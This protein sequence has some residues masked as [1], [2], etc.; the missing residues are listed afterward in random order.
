MTGIPV[1]CMGVF[2]PLG[3]RLAARVGPRM[4]FT[5]AVASIGM[6]GVLR[7]LAPAYPLILLATFGIGVAIGV[8]GALPAMV[9]AQRLPRTPALGTG[10]YVAGIAAG[11]TV[12][13]AVAVP[14][15]IDGDWRLSL[16]L[17]S[18]TTTVFL[19]AWLALVPNDHHE[20]RSSAVRPPLPWRSRT[21]W[22]LILVFGLE[23]GL[24]YGCV[25][26]LATI[27]V[28]RGWTT[29]AAG[30]LAAVFNAAGLA[31][32]LTVPLVADR[33]PHRGRV[34][35]VSAVATGLALVAVLNGS[36]LAYP[37]AVVLGFCLNVIFLLVLT[38]PLDVADE[39]ASVGSL[40]AL[41]LLGG[42]V[43]SATG[44]FVLGGIRDL[45]GDF[46][47]SI[48]AML[49]ATVALALVCL[50]LPRSHRSVTAT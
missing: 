20:Q 9:V 27:Y 30:S 34:M 2:A 41:M 24:F 45:T 37:A 44:P 46:T 4:A 14:L 42:Y 5:V 36:A 22:L 7:A 50:R 11:S 31:S 28:E 15:A 12:A 47:A 25:S 19:A 23:S 16:V 29:A 17:M 10:A 26:W 39:P 40:A 3:P 1:L 49:A 35:V 33:I 38:L 6:L 13:S 43:I 48:W 21:A 8:C 32:T 18:I